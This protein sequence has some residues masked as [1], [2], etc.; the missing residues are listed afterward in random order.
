VEEIP[1][2]VVESL[3]K[4]QKIPPPPPERRVGLDGKKYPVPPPPPP[5]FSVPEAPLPP[6]EAVVVRDETGL[7]IPEG[8]LPLWHRTPEA[9]QLLTEL[10]RIRGALRQAQ[11]SKDLL[12]AEVSY[13]TALAAAD[14][15]YASLKT[16]IPYAVCTSCQGKTKDQCVL[17]H[18]R[19]FISQFKWDTCVPK[20]TK[21]IRAKAQK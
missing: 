1:P 19:G 4:S 9:Q 7:P 5:R 11:E 17:C 2:E 20:E 8:L 16:A 15:L 18:K 14:Q 13:S 6:V 10:S 21:A 12:F 3:G